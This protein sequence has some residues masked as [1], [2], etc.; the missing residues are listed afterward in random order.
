M[1]IRSTLA[2]RLSLY[3]RIGYSVYAG[4]KIIII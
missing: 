3:D 2:G 4:G 1:A